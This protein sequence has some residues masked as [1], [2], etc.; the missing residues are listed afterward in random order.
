MSKIERAEVASAS[1]A[2]TLTLSARAV[3]GLASQLSGKRFA[4]PKRCLSQPGGIRLYDGGDRCHTMH[5]NL[6]PKFQQRSAEIQ[7]MT[8]PQR[9]RVTGRHLPDFVQC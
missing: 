4:A 5:D 6:W 7:V 8:R 2:E 9:E 1:L 3:S